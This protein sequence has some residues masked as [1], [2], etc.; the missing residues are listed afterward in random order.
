MPS[1][2]NPECNNLI[3]NGSMQYSLQSAVLVSWKKGAVMEIH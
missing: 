2:G 3:L 1:C